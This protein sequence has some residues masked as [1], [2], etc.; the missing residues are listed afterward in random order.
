M[1]L[2]G[3]DSSAVSFGATVGSFEA[4]LD[5]TRDVLAIRIDT[6]VVALFSALW[7]VHQIVLWNYKALFEQGHRIGMY[8]KLWMRE[9]S[10][11]SC[12]LS[13]KFEASGSGAFS[14]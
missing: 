4:G 5:S 7:V 1:E 11:N 6:L 2:L 9:Y 13:L 3:P 10:C 14:S 12:A 8:S